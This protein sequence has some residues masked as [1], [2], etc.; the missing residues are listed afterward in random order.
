[1]TDPVV[2]IGEQFLHVEPGDAVQTTLRIT[3]VGDQVEGYSIEICR[4]P[5]SRW[6]EAVPNTVHLLPGQDT[7]VTITFRPPRQPAPPVGNVTFGILVI[8]HI[9]PDRRAV[10]DGEIVVAEIHELQARLTPVSARGRHRGRYRIDVDNTGTAPASVLLRA[11]ESTRALS[12]ALAPTRLN[13]PAGASTSAFLLIRPVRPTL[14]GQQETL[15]FWIDYHTDAHPEQPG[16]IDGVFLRRPVIPRGLIPVVAT[17]LILTVAAVIA[18]RTLLPHQPPA[19]LTKAP[20]LAPVLRDVTP[21]GNDITITWTPVPLA[22]GY[23]VQQALSPQFSDIV[24]VKDVQP[25]VNV[26]TWPDVPPG[27][28]CFRVIA[29]DQVGRSDP[30]TTRCT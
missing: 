2:V 17:L 19:A 26:L 11:H 5:A 10:V 16:R 20:P 22:S 27:Q 13:T 28:H 9:D 3:N 12:L 25:D 15:P 29:V 23:T 8:S 30:S 6:A 7:E 4:G 24:D 14:L 18:L 1:M 21:T